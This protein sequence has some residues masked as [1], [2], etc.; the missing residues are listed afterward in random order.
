M[1]KPGFGQE[2]QRYNKEKN[3]NSISKV[4]ENSHGVQNKEYN[5]KE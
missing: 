3:Q 1:I 4:I 5:K 2:G